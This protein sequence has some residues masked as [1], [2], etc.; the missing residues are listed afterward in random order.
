MVVG[1]EPSAHGV[2]SQA[3]YSLD[4]PALRST[5]VFKYRAVHFAIELPR[6]WRTRR[7]A[8]AA[9]PLQNPNFT[10]RR[11]PR[12]RALYHSLRSRALAR[13]QKPGQLCGNPRLIVIAVLV[14]PLP[15]FPIA[16]CYFNM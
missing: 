4:S 11:A 6:R 8:V 12:A 2:H 13:T 14:N 7:S 1:N 15:R 9:D 5:R 3:R 10:V 16:A